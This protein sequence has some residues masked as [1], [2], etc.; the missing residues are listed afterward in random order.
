[1]LDAVC[2]SLVGAGHDRA[3]SADRR[4][5]QRTPVMSYEINSE[6]NQQPYVDII[7]GNVNVE[8]TDRSGTLRG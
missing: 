6:R 1:M 4:H 3:P 2:R 8:M 7:G 5:V